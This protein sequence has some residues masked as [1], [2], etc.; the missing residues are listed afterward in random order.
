MAEDGTIRD[1]IP[2]GP[3]TLLDTVSEKS[4]VNQIDIMGSRYT[5][6]RVAPGSLGDDVHHVH[7]MIDTDRKRISVDAERVLAEQIVLHEAI[8]GIFSECGIGELLDEKL[9]EA[10]VVALENGLWRAGYRRR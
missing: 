5:I 3:A 2:S 4:P 9:E 10:I 7:G 6:T 8:H 1:G